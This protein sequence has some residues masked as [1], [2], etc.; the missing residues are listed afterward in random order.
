MWDTR[1]A[2]DTANHTH[3]TQGVVAGDMC[4]GRSI[5]CFSSGYHVLHEIA[6]CKVKMLNWYQL[7]I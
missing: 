3:E 4:G 2:L 6:G 7:P 1:E 5:Y